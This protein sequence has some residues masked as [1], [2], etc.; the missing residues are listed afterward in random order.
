MTGGRA[1][2]RSAVNDASRRELDVIR[3]QLRRATFELDETRAALLQLGILFH[4]APVPIVLAD[5]AGTV[6]DLNSEAERVYSIERT[7]LLGRSLTALVPDGRRRIADRLIARCRNGKRIRHVE[8]LL[9]RRSNDLLS[10]GTTLTPLR[11]PDGAVVG[12]ALTED[13]RELKETGA[14]LHDVNQGLRELALIDGLTHLA[15]RRRFEQALEREVARARRGQRPLSLCMIDID[16]FK[17]FNDS[18]GHPAGD[19]CLF[20]VGQAIASCLRR[21][22]DLAARYGGEEFAVVLPETDAGGAAWI[23]ESMRARVQALE[24]AHPRSPVGPVVTVSIGVASAKAQPGLT[25]ALMVGAADRALY[26]A[27]RSGRNRVHAVRLRD[28]A[29][30]ASSAEG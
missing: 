7:Q 22:A 10:G 25:A 2:D 16:A 19:A 27:K 23:A 24:L 28:C 9:W 18:L 12:I 11:D 14:L 6:T 1:D 21:P 15:N 8:G 13:V 17:A 4:Q 20:A 29:P 5:P 26:A 3:E 30:D